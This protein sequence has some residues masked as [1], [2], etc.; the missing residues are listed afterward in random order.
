LLSIAV[1]MSSYKPRDLLVEC[2]AC[3]IE[4]FIADYTPDM[5]VVCNQCRERLIDLE[6]EE[7]FDEY[8]CEDCGM[9]LLLS[10][11]TEITPGES[12]CRCGSANL[13]LK[14]SP[15]IPRQAEEAGAFAGLPGDEEIDDFDWCRPSPNEAVS[16]D[17][18]DLFDKDPNF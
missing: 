12:T 15:S 3:Q 10:Q 18:N 7:S 13:S 5:P 4:N 14:P 2:R 6:L 16:E 9:V 11:D 8:E 17:Y 1:L